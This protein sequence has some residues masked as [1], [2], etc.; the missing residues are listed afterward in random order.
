MHSNGSLI[1]TQGL[2]MLRILGRDTSI[3]VRKVLWACAELGI[4]FTREDWGSGV[5]SAQ[6]SEFL[7]LNPNGLIPVIVD[8]DFV[9]WESHAILRYLAAFEAG[10]ALYPRQARARARID[11]WLD[12]Q[13]AELNPAWSYAYH[14]LVKHS[15]QH[16]D[17]ELTLASCRQWSQRMQVLEAQLQS[18]AA[19][20]VGEHLTLAD[21]SI[22]L[23]VNR[24]FHTPF[25]RPEL[26]AVSAYY[27]RLGEREGFRLYGRNGRP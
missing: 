19:Y 1:A 9:L 4:D 7:A 2:P 8:D 5:R 10:E 6:S 17:P 11:Q 24:W 27:E 23:S 21:I 14:N 15:A 22:G 18:T 26:P 16:C 12:W 25:E 13:A 3:N 20:V